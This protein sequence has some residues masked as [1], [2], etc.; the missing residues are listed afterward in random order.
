MGSRVLPRELADAHTM[1]TCP[2][3]YE[4]IDGRLKYEN[5]LQGWAWAHHTALKVLAKHVPHT[6]K[7]RTVRTFTNN[8]LI[9][10]QRLLDLH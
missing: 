1:T 4:T 8:R 6:G 10:F 2:I 9:L 3:H 7:K 5:P